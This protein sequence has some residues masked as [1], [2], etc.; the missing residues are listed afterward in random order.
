VD[1]ISKY[2]SEWGNPVTKEHTWYA[3]PCKW[4]LAQ[5]LGIPKMQFINYMKLKKKED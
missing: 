1:G 2:H 5:K 3:L 4:L